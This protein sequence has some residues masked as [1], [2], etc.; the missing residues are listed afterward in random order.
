MT[1]YLKPRRPFPTGY[2]AMSTERINHDLPT[3]QIGTVASASNPSP[4]AMQLPEKLTV[5]AKL[6][7]IKGDAKTTEIIMYRQHQGFTPCKLYESNKEIGING[8]YESLQILFEAVLD[9]TLSDDVTV[10]NT[11]ILFEKRFVT[12]GNIT[13]AIHQNLVDKKV[14][15]TPPGMENGQPVWGY[16]GYY[17][18]S[19]TLDQIEQ[20]L[21]VPFI[22]GTKTDVSL[23]RAS[24][25]TKEGTTSHPRAVLME[26]V[27]FTSL[28]GDIE[29]GQVVLQ[30]TTGIDENGAHLGQEYTSIAFQQNDPNIPYIEI[31]FK[32][33]KSHAYHLPRS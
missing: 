24:V 32:K 31:T 6:N 19:C 30:L 9:K 20:I 25:W 21:F 17:K 14:I 28:A 26:N 11:S 33:G 18:E 16:G 29:T 1:F 22:N 12:Q 10:T 2:T 23:A 3:F 8:C 15:T 7:P 27:N 13:H 4:F 5:K